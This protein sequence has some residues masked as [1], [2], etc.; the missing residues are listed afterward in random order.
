MR[1]KK[2]TKASVINAKPFPEGVTPGLFD[3]KFSHAS[4][5]PDI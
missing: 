4:N 1:R 5:I 3:H 2:N